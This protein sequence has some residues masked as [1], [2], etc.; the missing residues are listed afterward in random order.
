[1]KTGLLWNTYRGDF[2]WY[3]ISARSYVKFATG[4]HRA[5][6]IVPRQDFEMFRQVN[7]P[8]GIETVPHDDYPG[9]SFVRHMMMHCWADTLFPDCDWIAHIDADCVFAKPSTPETWFDSQGRNI[10]AYRPFEDLLTEPIKPGEEVAFMGASGLK[11]EMNRGQY[12]WRWATEF[13]LGRSAEWETMQALPLFYPREVYPKLREEMNARHGNW[14][15]YVLSSREEY[16]QSFAEFNALGEVAKHSFSDR[17]FFHKL[18]DVKFENYPIWRGH[19]IQAWSRGGLDRVHDF[20]SDGWGVT[21]PRA[22]HQ[23]LG[24]E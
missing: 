8:I 21:T 19:V 20:S 5:R 17:Y 14:E 9:K 11:S 23:K 7:Q 13:A 4:F 12:L 24:V 3:K 18:D 15:V 1:M 2:E 16:P 6:C 10:M 22:I